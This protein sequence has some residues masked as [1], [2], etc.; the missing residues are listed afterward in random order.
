[1]QN[2]PKYDNN[3]ILKYLCPTLC[4]WKLPLFACFPLHFLSLVP[5]L[6]PLLPSIHRCESTQTVL[7]S[8]LWPQMAQGSQYRH[9][10]PCDWPLVLP[11][12]QSS[13]GID[14]VE[15]GLCLYV[16][17]C[18]LVGG[19]Q[20]GRSPVSHKHTHTPLEQKQYCLT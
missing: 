11:Q 1:M 2:T 20:T 19:V 17:V 7:P 5:T 8:C 6:H 9:E 12:T 14:E 13:L 3:R 15:G 16:C 4:T 18:V 10:A